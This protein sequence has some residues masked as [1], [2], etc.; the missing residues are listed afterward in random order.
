MKIKKILLFISMFVMLSCSEKQVWQEIETGKTIKVF[1]EGLKLDNGD[2][3]YKWSKPVGPEGSKFEYTIENDK[4]LFTALTLGEYHVSV[5]VENKISEIVHEE[6]F[7]FNAIK[8]NF[9]VITEKPTKKTPLD[10]KENK[11]KDIS[12]PK[13]KQN[14]VKNRFT[15]QVASWTS[16][17]KA[18]EDMDE[19]IELGFDTYIE[20][21][22][23]KKNNIQRWRVRI[24]SFK[25]KDL[26]K[27]VKEELS[28]FRGETPW[29][30]YIK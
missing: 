1:P 19:L 13:E 25:S 21:Y 29:I 10:K 24:G 5:E 8:G 2:Y 15:I 27:Q 14:I 20:E 12:E 17:D 30:S 23:D 22:F 4:L 3:I 16:L 11:K 9:E 6:T 7:Y 28:K 26:A 18:K